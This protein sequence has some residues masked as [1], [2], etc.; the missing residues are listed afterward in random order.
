MKTPKAVL[1]AASWL[2]E[3]FD[4]QLEYLGTYEGKEAFVFNPTRED[5]CIGF[6][7]TYLYEEGKPVEEITG[8]EALDILSFFAPLEDV[9]E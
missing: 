8:F 5:L 3:Q 7:H 2:T 4:G 1:E 6:P 9:E